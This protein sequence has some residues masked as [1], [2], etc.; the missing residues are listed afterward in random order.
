MCLSLLKLNIT[1][2]WLQFCRGI[3]LES[4]NT[5]YFLTFGNNGIK[6]GLKYVFLKDGY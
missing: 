6:C 3:F 2:V 4:Q 5:I 1:S